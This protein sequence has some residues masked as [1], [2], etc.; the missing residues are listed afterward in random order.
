MADVLGFAE[1][2]DLL[3]DIFCV[4]GNAFE[5]F[6]G[7]HPVEAPADG[8]GIGH[9]V[10]R[11]GPVN[12]FVERVHLLVTR[13]DGAGGGGIPVYKRVER[14]LDHVER[15]AG[16]ARQVQGDFHGR[17]PAQIARALGNLRSLIADAFKV[18]GNFHRHGDEAQVGGQ[19]RLGEELNDQFVNLHFELV[20]DAVV[21]LHPHRE[22]G[23]A[24][25]ERL[26]GLVHGGLG[27]AGHQQQLLLQ[28]VQFHL[29]VCFHNFSIL[30]L[31]LN[32]NL[33]SHPATAAT[34]CK[35]D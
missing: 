15:E 34:N 26:H 20:N 33:D 27:V 25:D 21:F 4:V 32:L 3:G 5:A 29:E 30:H 22:I 11:E 17:F 35:R 31:H 14:G 2:N 23:I 12:L 7:D 28:T 1:I 18:L 16:H 13:D 24:L 9:H 6:G 19:R 10:L 8:A